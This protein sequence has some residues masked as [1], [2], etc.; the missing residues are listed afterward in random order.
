[1]DV[2]R[3]M[4]AVI[5]ARGEAASASADKDAAVADFRRL[6]ALRPDLLSGWRSLGMVLT[7]HHRTVEAGERALDRALTLEPGDGPSLWWRAEADWLQGAPARAASRLARV[8]PRPHVWEGLAL[9][10]A[11]MESEALLAFERAEREAAEWGNAEERSTGYRIWYLDLMGRRDEAE[12]LVRELREK[13]IRRI[14]P[15]DPGADDPASRLERLRALVGG[16]DICV[17]ASG[18]SLAELGRLL[19]DIGSDRKE[20]CFFVFN[21][22][23][24]TEAY[25]RSLCGRDAELACFTAASVADLHAGWVADYLERPDPNL[26]LTLAAARPRERRAAAAFDRHPDRLLLFNAE[27][28]HPPIPSDPLHFPPIN[29]LL[30]VVALAAAARPR[31]VFLFGCD[32]GSPIDKDVPVYFRQNDAMYGDQKIENDGYARWLARDT[33]L[34]NQIMPTVLTCLSAF[35]D[36]PLPPILNCAPNSSYTTFP[37]VGQT[38]PLMKKAD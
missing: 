33:Y 38:P 37:L 11:G 13:N 19:N 12:A 1:M 8:V 34:F 36:A 29:T 28:T 22:A 16:R 30:I 5:E 15:P 4:E 10:A 6:L 32:G 14:A 27:G 7:N 26:Y 17:L 25:L 31:R 23:P 18:P 3:S 2:E 35:C 24:V 20:I 9:R 21:N